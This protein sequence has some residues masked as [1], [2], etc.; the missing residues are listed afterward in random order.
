VLTRGPRGRP[1]CHCPGRVDFLTPR[2]SPGLTAFRG[3]RGKHRGARRRGVR[4][5]ATRH[6]LAPCLGLPAAGS[7]RTGTST[8]SD[9]PRRAPAGHRTGGPQLHEH[10][11]VQPRRTLFGSSC[12]SAPSYPPYQPPAWNHQIA[13]RHS[14]PRAYVAIGMSR[15]SWPRSWRRESRDGLRSHAAGH[16][17]RAT[18]CA[19]DVRAVLCDLAEVV[20]GLLI[21]GSAILPHEQG[22]QRAVLERS[23]SAVFHRISAVLRAALA[24]PFLGPRLVPS[25]DPQCPSSLGP[26]SVSQ[27][28]WNGSKYWSRREGARSSIFMIL[29]P[30]VPSVP[31]VAFQAR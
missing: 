2:A 19:G 30:S 9:S 16:Y 27:T 17:C 23:E 10:L 4:C 24:R 15:R 5:F 22:P 18:R 28:R 26:L 29:S 3:W 7:G 8:A 6:E 14:T 21:W 11:G 31:I 13:A 25:A 20:G 12:R 1:R